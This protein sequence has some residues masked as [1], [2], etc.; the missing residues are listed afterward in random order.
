MNIETIAEC[1]RL[2]FADTPF[3]VVVGKL[4]GAG[5]TAYTADLTAEQARRRQGARSARRPA[6]TLR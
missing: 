3:P 1:L 6:C 2:S 5:V 4:A